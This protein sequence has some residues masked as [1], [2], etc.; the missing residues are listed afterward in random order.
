MSVLDAVVL[1]LETAGGPLHYRGITHRIIESSLWN[2]RSKNPEA[3]VIAQLAGDIKK[4][5]TDSRF[6]RT[7]PGHYALNP[8]SSIKS[9]SGEQSRPTNQSDI[10]K[11]N[12]KLS[13]TDAA[14]R[15][16]SLSKALE[17]LHYRII[18]DRALEFGLI[19]TDSLT[20]SASMYSSLVSEI[21]RRE[22][23]GDKPRF[24]QHGRGL[25][26][27][28]SW[29]P[30]GVVDRIED[31][32]RNVRKSLLERVRNADADNFENLVGELLSAMGFE[33]VEVTSKNN[34]GGIDVRGTLVV[35]EAVRI[36][37]AVQAK[38]WSNN[39]L[40]PIVQ[41]VRGALGAHE[42]GLIITTSNFSSGAKEEANR[43]DAGPV[44]LIN[45]EQL[46]SLLA[47]YRIGIRAETYDI[48]RLE[49]DR[50]T[51]G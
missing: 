9:T 34:D 45:G 47:Q 15:I 4:R 27:L 2:T 23:K 25:I 42:R 38:R 16:L 24:V 11:A 36:N 43:Q 28:A 17:P 8:G 1:V 12:S 20:P 51:E 44:Y 33:D 22:N 13:F 3:T 19:R 35:G 26:G 50:E 48:L 32:N 21:R 30:V 49:R 18:T 37:M 5:G 14:E 41:Q 10:G 31:N 40:K 7:G 39:V 46:A 6:I 29:L